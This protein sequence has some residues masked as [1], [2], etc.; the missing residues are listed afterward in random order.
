MKDAL[1]ISYFLF[2]TVQGI[3][4]SQEDA[5]Q[6][7]EKAV[8]N[9]KTAFLGEENKPDIFKVPLFRIRNKSSKIN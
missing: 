5:K 4:K 9:H 1:L 6:E 7:Y 8:K 3:V 2:Y